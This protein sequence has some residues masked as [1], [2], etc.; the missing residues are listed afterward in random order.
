M[1]LKP[2]FQKD[3]FHFKS[4]SNEKETKF[5]KRTKHLENKVLGLTGLIWTIVLRNITNYQN[6]LL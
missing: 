3:I 2:L 6:N 5:N 4:D 1:K